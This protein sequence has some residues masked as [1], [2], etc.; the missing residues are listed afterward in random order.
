MSAPDIFWPARCRS[1]TPAR[2]AR[3]SLQH[4]TLA[5][6]RLRRLYL[7]TPAYGSSCHTYECTGESLAVPGSARHPRQHLPSTPSAPSAPNAPQQL[8]TSGA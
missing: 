6:P 3:S 5:R 1:S 2:S 8:D 4:S 7:I